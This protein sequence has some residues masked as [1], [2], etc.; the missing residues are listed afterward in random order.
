MRNMR[1]L[2]GACMETLRIYPIAGALPRYVAQTFDFGGHTIP[3]GAL[4][5]VA[6]GVTHF[7][8]AIYREPYRFDPDRFFAPRNEHHQPGVFAPYGLGGR[9]CLSAG[10]GEA[11]I[12]LV[13][14]TLFRNL[15]LALPTPDYRLKTEI[16]PIP[17]PNRKFAVRVV[18]KRGHF[19]V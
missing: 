3:Q 5:F 2:Y 18:E 12:M 19:S 4:V 14:A 7:V 13:I 9:T 8:P 1:W 15:R 6:T 11:L 16:A 10:M 17:G